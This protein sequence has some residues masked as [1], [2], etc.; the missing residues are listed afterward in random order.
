M[1]RIEDKKKKNKSLTLESS[2]KANLKKIS[3]IALRTTF[4]PSGHTPPAAASE[5]TKVEKQRSQASIRHLYGAGYGEEGGYSSRPS[6]PSRPSREDRDRPRE[7][8]DRP[9]GDRDRPRGDRDRPFHG[10]P[11]PFSGRPRP[12]GDRDRPF[13]DRPSRP[14]RPFHD[15]PHGGRPR[16][17]PPIPE[18]S[19]GLLMGLGLAGLHASGNKKGFW[20]KFKKALKRVRR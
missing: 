3:D 7:D 20:N 5:G 9:R 1:A 12:H 11:G 16:P 2:N 15:R 4:S 19:S 18:P 17:R 14:N 8:R 13:H 6:R 10:R